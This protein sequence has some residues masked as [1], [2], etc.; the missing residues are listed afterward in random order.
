VGLETFETG[1]QTEFKLGTHGNTQDV[2]DAVDKVSYVGGGGTNTGDALKHLRTTSFSTAFGHRAGVPKLAIVV[3]DGVS[4]YKNRTKEQARLAHNSGITVMA[5]GVGKSTD[6]VELQDIASDPDSKYLFH[7]DAFVG[8][9]MIESTLASATCTK[10]QGLASDCAE[11][12]AADIVF[13]LD[14]SGSV[15]V[16]NFD[17]MKNFTKS[18][19]DE[20]AIGPNA[21]QFGIVIFSTPVI[22]AFKLNQYSDREELKK[23]IDGIEFKDGETHTGKALEYLREHTFTRQEGYRSNPNIPKVAIV[24]TDGHSTHKDKTKEQAQKLKEQDVE[25]YSIG[26]GNDVDEEELGN[27]ASNKNVFRVDTFSALEHLRPLLLR[28]VCKAK[29]TCLGKSDVVFLLDSSCSVGKENFQKLK[30]FVSDV[31]Y[32]LYIDKNGIQM[33]VE[34]YECK[35]H[36]NF[37]LNRFHNKVQM[38]SAINNIEY[39]PG[40]TNTGEAIKH[41]W[42]RSFSSDYGNRDN[43]KKIGIVITDGDSKSKATTFYEAHKARESGVTMVAIGVGDMDVEELRGIANGTDYLYTTKS[44][45]TLR[46]LTKKMTAL[47]CET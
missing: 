42:T 35:V 27:M 23:A 45:D 39:K 33:G 10:L 3:T 16:E 31:T 17:L 12:G 15:G 6:Q 24:I 19:V 34:S 26:V 37:E 14:S 29:N 9:K 36:T 40:G 22:G 41:M 46:D 1:V 25:I 2:L 28:Q 7:I 32:N 11:K 30:H 43:V 20:F 5:V 18:I 8:L 47:A 21:V 44:Y 13:L 4:S 38:Q